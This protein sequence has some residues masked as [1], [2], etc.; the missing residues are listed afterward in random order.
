MYFGAVA[1]KH[2]YFEVSN[3]TAVVV[4][5]VNVSELVIVTKIHRSELV[6]FVFLC[7]F[8]EQI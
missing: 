3:V 4:A 5:A 7:I 2:Y 6:D 8:T 1:D